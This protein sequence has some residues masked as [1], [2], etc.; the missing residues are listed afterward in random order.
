MDHVAMVARGVA[1]GVVKAHV[2]AAALGALE[3]ATR[4]EPG[5]GVGVGE[6]PVQ[7]LAG[8]DDARVAP[9]RGAGASFGDGR[10]GQPAKR[11][12]LPRWIGR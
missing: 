3:R 9:Q 1:V 10:R 2:C 6:Q 11:L 7:S 12:D 5:Q 8:A 4:H